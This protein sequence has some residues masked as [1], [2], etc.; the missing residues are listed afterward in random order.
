MP[1]PR[2]PTRRCCSAGNGVPEVGVLKGWD[3]NLQGGTTNPP[4]LWEVMG[5]WVVMDVVCNFCK[6]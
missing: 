6:N 3:L 4:Q 2:P 5:R 1:K